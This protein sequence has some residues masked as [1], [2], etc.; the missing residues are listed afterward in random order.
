MLR[1]YRWLGVF[2][3]CLLLANVGCSQPTLKSASA[4]GTATFSGAPLAGARVTIVPENGPVSLCI[5]GVDGKFKVSSIAVGPVKI[6]IS[7]DA[8]EDSADA[9]KDVSQPPK[10]DADAQ[11]YLKRAAEL[12]KEM[13][14]K[15]KSGKKDQTKKVTL[16]PA[17]Y[18]KADT[19]GL[20]FTVKE[21]G[22]NHFEIKL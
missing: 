5:T 10:S 14:D 13:I 11:A 1:A 3:Y 8:T 2:W 19:S 6:A 9:F 7:V 12:Q 17:K 4:D 15:A 16:L 21:N 18:G 20:N 22:D